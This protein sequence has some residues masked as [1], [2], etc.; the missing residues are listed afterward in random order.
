MISN[1]VQASNTSRSLTPTPIVHK[2]SMNKEDADTE[3]TSSQ[4][5]GS[6]IAKSLRPV[7][8]LDSVCARQWL[9]KKLAYEEALLPLLAQ[10]NKE[11][12]EK[13]KQKQTEVQEDRQ[14][15]RDRV[16]YSDQRVF[17]TTV[18]R[19][20][21]VQLTREDVIGD[22]PR[23]ARELWKAVQESLQ[24]VKCPGQVD[25]EEY[26]EY[27][28]WVGCNTSSM[29]AATRNR[30]LGEIPRYV[31]GFPLRE[32]LSAPSSS[33]PISREYTKKHACLQCSVRGL[34]CSL[35]RRLVIKGHKGK[36]E[37]A[38]Q[39][40]IRHKEEH[41]CLVAAK[42]DKK[43]DEVLTW[44]LACPHPELEDDLEAFS[45]ES[46]DIVDKWMRRQFETG[47][48]I[49]GG[50]LVEVSRPLFVL[51]R[52]PMDYEFKRIW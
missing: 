46:Q 44:R 10:R 42:V 12:V 33:K 14:Y 29:F 25:E 17:E 7:L 37:K 5:D 50:V 15:W 3:E 51:P 16:F 21:L 6:G 2:T 8:S 24:M 34:P 35:T 49:V 45:H 11:R 4:E 48:D 23:A 52:K 1:L 27:V 38:C 22:R 18:V 31:D 43:Q 40:C 20:M 39:R 28:A 32:A 30:L 9:D 13:I 36:A 26:D 47:V 19:K 41:E